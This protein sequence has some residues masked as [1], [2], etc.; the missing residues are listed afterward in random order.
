MGRKLLHDY[1]HCELLQRISEPSQFKEM[2]EIQKRPATD[3]RASEQRS[4]DGACERF[5]TLPFSPVFPARTAGEHSAVITHSGM[6][7]FAK[8]TLRRIPP[9]ECHYLLGLTIPDQKF[10]T[11][12]FSAVRTALKF[13][14]YLANPSASALSGCI[15][16]LLTLANTLLRRNASR[17]SLPSSER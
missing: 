5:R 3:G 11:A 2:L 8:K 6:E 17:V 14:R 9:A 4:T 1:S 13:S 10:S 7:A 15:V 12:A 16:V